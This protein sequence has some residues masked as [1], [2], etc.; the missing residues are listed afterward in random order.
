MSFIL[1]SSAKTNW[2]FIGIVAILGVLVFIGALLLFPIQ[3]EVPSQGQITEP[4]TLPVDPTANWQTYRNEEFDYQLKHPT[5]WTISTGCF[6]CIVPEVDVAVMRPLENGGFMGALTIFTQQKDSGPQHFFEWLESIEEKGGKEIYIGGVKAWQLPDSGID[7]VLERN[8]IAY[9]IIILEEAT[10]AAEKETIDQILSTFRFIEPTDSEEFNTIIEDE[11][12]KLVLSLTLEGTLDGEAMHTLKFWQDQ[13]DPLYSSRYALFEIYNE[14]EKIYENTYEDNMR[15]IWNAE[16]I[17]IDNNNSEEIILHISSGGNC[18]SC[19]SIQV[20]QFKQDDLE[21]ISISA[22]DFFVP[23]RVE[24]INED[25]T[26]EVVALLTRWEFAF[27]LCHACSPGTSRVYKWENGKYIKA[28]EEFPE[29]YEKEIK[30]SE[31]RLETEPNSSFLI[32]DIISILLNRI[33]MGK[34]EGAWQQFQ[35]RINAVD[36]E[37]SQREVIINELQV[38]YSL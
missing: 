36:M 14:E 22:E 30:R 12:N 8:G 20:F 1:D 37:D 28:S 5:E 4:K 2:K 18:W 7:I 31:D 6:G 29:F 27:G 21:E 25:G 34:S 16:L 23:K 10:S 11:S 13:S 9:G 19:S 26:S 17:D 33:E 3:K 24:D 15:T 35:E 32:G 38:F